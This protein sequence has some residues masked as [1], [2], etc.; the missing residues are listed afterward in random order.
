LISHDRGNIAVLSVVL[1]A[2]VC[3]G[4][5][6]LIKFVDY[7]HGGVLCDLLYKRLKLSLEG[8]VDFIVYI[9]H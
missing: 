3:L 6:S 9:L 1:Q 2:S 5:G 4:K 7:M 8:T